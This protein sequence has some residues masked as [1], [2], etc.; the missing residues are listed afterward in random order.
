MEAILKPYSRQKKR[1]Y[2]ENK[3]TKYRKMGQSEMQMLPTQNNN[4]SFTGPLCEAF[5]NYSNIHNFGINLDELMVEM[6]LII[7]F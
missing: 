3:R 5:I 1:G 2:Q 4:V 7:H 6:F